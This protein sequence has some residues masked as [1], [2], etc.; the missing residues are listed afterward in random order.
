[1]YFFLTVEA[2]RNAIAEHYDRIVGNPSLTGIMEGLLVIRPVGS[3]RVGTLGLKR[4]QVAGIGYRKGK[5][6]HSHKLS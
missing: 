1:L 6:I 2:R 3:E 5:V 4:A